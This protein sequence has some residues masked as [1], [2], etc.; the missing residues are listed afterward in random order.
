MC[1]TEMGLLGLGLGF[2]RRDLA[3]LRGPTAPRGLRA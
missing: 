3:T 2:G 1:P